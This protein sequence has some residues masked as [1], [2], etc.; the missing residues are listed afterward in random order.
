MSETALPPSTER[1][2]RLTRFFSW[3]CLVGV[4]AVTV[5]L[6]WVSRDLTRRNLIDHESAANVALTRALSNDLWDRYKY[7]VTN[8]AGR[9]RAELLADPAQQQLKIDLLQRIRGLNVVNIKVYN[10]DGLVVHSTDR[11]QIGEV[12][13]QSPEFRR[14]RKG[15]VTSGLTFRDSV[16]AHQGTLV[17]RDLIYSYI[18]VRDNDDA[19]PE[20]VVEV[21]TDVTEL[22]ERQTRAQWQ[23]A[24]F[25][26]LLLG[27]LYLFLHAVVRRA[28]HTIA[29]HELDRSVREAEIR[30]RAQHDALTGLANRSHFIERLAGS[31]SL[32]QRSGRH[33]ALMFIDLD[34][35]KIV[36]DS[37]GH[38]A[39]DLLLKT[40]AERIRG[41]MRRSDMLFRMGGDEFT[42]ILPEVAKPEDAGDLAQRIIDV[43]SA[44]IVLHEH[45]VSVGATIGIAV[46]PGDGDDAEALVRNADAA[47]YTAKQSGRGA[48]AFYRSSMNERALYRLRV[49]AAMHRAAR[50]GAFVL[51]YQTRLDSVT[52]E[53]VAMEA[54]LRWNH[55]ERGLVAPAEFI[56]V[57][58]DMDLMHEVGEWVLRSACVQQKRWVNEGLPAVRMSVNVSALQFQS[59]RFADTV[60][61][62]LRQTG[63]VPSAIELELTESM[64]ITRPDQACETIDMLKA[65][66]VRISLDD[67]GT[68]YS[69]LGYLHRF[70]VDCLKID[71]SFVREVDTNP[72]DRAVTQAIVQMARALGI[73]VVAEGVETPA[74]ADFLSQIGC[75]ELQGY[76]FCRP[77]AP[78]H[79]PPLLR[80]APYGST[81]KTTA[82]RA[83]TLNVPVPA[84]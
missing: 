11:R 55:P 16:D 80:R 69:S 81:T 62:V 72:R 4:L 13:S 26:L 76:L 21:Q 46:F 17:D 8:S 38:S 28:D 56:D 33:G 82:E 60:A 77:Q 75:D 9:S 24:G 84:V 14:A 1:P 58:E 63:V 15:L 49:E 79:I 22:L 42:A 37:L 59:P 78:E 54:L 40:V 5:V 61:R 70:A 71:R 44:P 67:F 32:A 47:M 31:M 19:M 64:L 41:C 7:F 27:A 57:L 43:V 45:R 50:E 29:R 2:F 68:G 51:H 34:R 6:I 48:H 66:D 52:R 73:G 74:Q 25:V 53:V 18:P 83:G 36:N 65:L 30:H 35:F 10:L 12:Q 23:G 39:G 3:A 20:C